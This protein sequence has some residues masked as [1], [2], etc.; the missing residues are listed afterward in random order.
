MALRSSNSSQ[1]RIPTVEIPP[2]GVTAV[3]PSGASAASGK[4]QPAGTHSPSTS[5]TANG[6]TTSI[7]TAATTTNGRTIV[8][9]G[10]NGTDLNSQQAARPAGFRDRLVNLLQPERFFSLKTSP[11][12]ELTIYSSNED[13]SLSEER[14]P[15]GKNSPSKESIVSPP[16][17]SEPRRIGT[18]SLDSNV[19]SP[20]PAA[21]TCEE[22]PSSKLKKLF[23]HNHRPFLELH[24]NESS[25]LSSLDANLDSASAASATPLE[26]S[27]LTKLRKFEDITVSTSSSSFRKVLP[28][29]NGPIN[30][31]SQEDRPPSD[32]QKKQR[33][34]VREQQMLS[35]LTPS[36]LFDSLLVVTLLPQEADT[37]PFTK[38]TTI[39]T[40]TTARNLR[41]MVP[42]ITYR[43]PPETPGSA[44]SSQ[45]S[46]DS[47]DS[48][49]SPSLLDNIPL[50]C[51]PDGG[52][53]GNG[54]TLEDFLKDD[55]H[56]SRSSSSSNDLQSE[57]FS[58]V[59]TD[60]DGSKRFGYCRRLISD[61]E[62]E[63]E[64]PVK[65]PTN[66]RHG[67]NV[68]IV[69]GV[70]V[71]TTYIRKK[72][73]V[74]EVYCIISPIGCFSLFQQILDIVERKKATSKSDIYA[75]L[76]AVIAQPFPKPGRS[77]TVRAFTQQGSSSLEE[78]ILHRPVD[79]TNLEHVSFTQ[80]L[81]CMGITS[82]SS[83]HVTTAQPPF[84][85]LITL[86]SALLLERHI[87][88]TS[89]SLQKLSDCCNAA[90]ALIYPLEWQHVFI[91]ILP[92]K[93]LDFVCSPTPYLI[94]M[95]A[96]D[97]GR[98]V[99]GYRD[100]TAPA[101]G[102]GA[103]IGSSTTATSTAVSPSSM[104]SLL[105]LED[106]LV[107]NLDTGKIL[108]H[109]TANQDR[110]AIPAFLIH[111]LKGFLE[112]AL[113]T[114]IDTETMSVKLPFLGVKNSNKSQGSSSAS[115]GGTSLPPVLPA[116]PSPRSSGGIPAFNLL[117]I[118]NSDQISATPSFPLQRQTSQASSISSVASSGPP[119]QAN[120]QALAVTQKRNA[121]IGNA[122][123]KLFVMLVGPY[124]DYME[125]EM[126][127][128]MEMEMAANGARATT[129]SLPT[130]KAV[131]IGP[132]KVRVWFD[133]DSFVK[134]HPLTVGQESVWLSEVTTTPTGV[135][136]NPIPSTSQRNAIRTFLSQVAQSQHLQ[137]FCQAR[138]EAFQYHYQMQLQGDQQQQPHL[139]EPNTTATTNTTATKK[140]SKKNLPNGQKAYYALAQSMF[141]KKITQL[142]MKFQQ[143]MVDKVVQ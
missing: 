76:K 83:L 84:S 80:F 85:V 137:F 117:S 70:P 10:V 66:N 74:P 126:E 16:A 23:S 79:L 33:P 64:V 99:E 75:F 104:E 130:D 119:T 65:V 140:P 25:S 110:A 20:P 27:P 139:V 8:Y 73:R 15:S 14:I 40:T 122:F 90:I 17:D 24:S 143:R 6:T 58:F 71:M 68:E 21:A 69:N 118:S 18:P 87:I 109:D 78:F 134:Y 142:E 13:T 52:S 36:K 100:E 63:G 11:S 94:G 129:P 88:L 26:P 113:R 1:A 123:M 124:R 82:A 135:Q 57:T 128:E 93:L 61:Q 121:L 105:P 72:K 29:A 38:S 102:G 77:I 116:P 114:H 115:L 3:A 132:G 133:M 120:L 131:A 41:I 51:F 107:I 19:H 32:V 95:L 5:S 106:A 22:K 31:Q 59:L 86:L 35:L 48:T 34:S 2:T 103:T 125:V 96:A 7:P 37:I 53:T 9:G 55:R 45:S 54:N 62:V 42:K 39:T 136:L 43:F 44:K 101:I 89:K 56:S 92:R 50:F 112:E 49:T 4:S 97:V 30:T 67:K 81:L 138:E 46:L 47:A 111:K 60:F 141:E 108:R 91:P 12:K 98:V 127:A 28:L